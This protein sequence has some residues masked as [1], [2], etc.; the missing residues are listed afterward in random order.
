[1]SSI[2]SAAARTLEKA[3][4]DIAASRFRW[5]PAAASPWW[6]L[7]KGLTGAAGSR[8]GISI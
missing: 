6:P 4:E 2:P 3:L 1:M 8:F 5:E 7:P